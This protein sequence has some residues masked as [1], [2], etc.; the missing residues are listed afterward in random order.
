ML[1]LSLEAMWKT[2]YKPRTVVRFLKH[3]KGRKILVA[4]TRKNIF[5]FDR[6]TV[7]WNSNQRHW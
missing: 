4:T 3:S 6:C 2:P 1:A 7:L 5:V